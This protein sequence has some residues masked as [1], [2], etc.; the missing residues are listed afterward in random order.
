M[1]NR[2]DAAAH[3]YSELRGGEAGGGAVAHAAYQ[4]LADQAPEGLT[5]RDRPD[6]TVLLPERR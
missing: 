4:E 6:S 3:R 1:H 5:N 2:L